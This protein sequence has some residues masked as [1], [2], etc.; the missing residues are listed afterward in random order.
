MC[1]LNIMQQIVNKLHT[2]APLLVDFVVTTVVVF[3]VLVVPLD[4]VTL[5]GFFLTG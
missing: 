3:V 2:I 4:G 1:Y 5:A